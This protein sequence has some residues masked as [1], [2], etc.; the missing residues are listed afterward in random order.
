MVRQETCQHGPVQN[1]DLAPD[2]ECVAAVM[3][4]EGEDKQ[5]TQN[6]VIFLLNFFDE[7]RRRVP[8]PGK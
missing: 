6:R 8:L 7:L 2:G 3:L 1:L 4:A 5:N